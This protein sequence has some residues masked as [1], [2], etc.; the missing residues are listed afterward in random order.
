MISDEPDVSN[1]LT[2]THSC[3]T[4]IEAPEESVSRS[5]F[6]YTSSGPVGGVECG[7]GSRQRNQP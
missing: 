6:Y 2:R 5:G 1:S 7:T 3:L 4:S